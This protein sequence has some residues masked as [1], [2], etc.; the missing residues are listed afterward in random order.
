MVATSADDAQQYGHQLADAVDAAL[1]E[2]QP[3]SGNQLLVRRRSI[4]LPLRKGEPQ[5]EAK[6]L[7]TK[8][9]AA[10]I[11]N[12]ALVFLPGEPFIELALAIRK[13]LPLP[14]SPPSWATPKTTS[15]TSPP[16]ELSKT[17]ATKPAPAAGPDS[18]PGSEAIVRDQTIRLLENL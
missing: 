5:Q 6:T 4:H 18:P 13:S 14:P 9:A 11:G 3:A 10:R 17:A 7:E 8:I 12:T 2:S 1:K 16:T 15:A